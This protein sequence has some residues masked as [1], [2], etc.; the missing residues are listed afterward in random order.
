VDVLIAEDH[1]DS[2]EILKLLL[3]HSGHAVTAVADGVEALAALEE[4]CFDAVLLDL[5]MPRMG[6]IETVRRIRQD[7]AFAAL[8]VY[9]V[10][11]HTSEEL[12]A[13]LAASGFTGSLT[14]PY[15]LQQLNNLLGAR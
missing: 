1:A 7:P 6:G 4:L 11:A 2:R 13:E 10:S 3:T 15:T 12:S 8:P 5:E 14:K 9:A